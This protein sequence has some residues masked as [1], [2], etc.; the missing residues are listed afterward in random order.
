MNRYPADR[1]A[2]ADHDAERRRILQG[3]AGMAA[4]LAWPLG[5][6]AAVKES[7]LALPLSASRIE[8]NFELTLARTQVNFTAAPASAITLNGTIPRAAAA[9]A[10]RRRSQ[11]CADQPPRRKPL[12]HTGTG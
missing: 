9:H 8:R 5:A 3:T 12:P 7:H 10:R 4:M 1:R 11:H 6:D 2:D